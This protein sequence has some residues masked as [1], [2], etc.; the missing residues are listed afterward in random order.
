[1][2]LTVFLL[3]GIV[4]F[5]WSCWVLVGSAKGKGSFINED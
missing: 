1:M 5:L 4:G 3:R 2:H